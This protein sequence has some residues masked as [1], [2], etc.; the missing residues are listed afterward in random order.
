MSLLKHCSEYLQVGSLKKT[1]NL[2]SQFSRQKLKP[3]KTILKSLEGKLEINKLWSAHM[4][5]FY[6]VGMPSVVFFLEIS[7]K[8]VAVTDTVP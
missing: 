8:D 4:R 3:S 7:Q 6:L 5:E 2:Y 1:S